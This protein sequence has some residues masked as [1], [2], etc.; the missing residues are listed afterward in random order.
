[1]YQ[2]EGQAGERLTSTG[3]N[4]EREDPGCPTHVLG[5]GEGLQHARDLQ[6]LAWPQQSALSCACQIY[7]KHFHG[8][9]CLTR[10]RFLAIHEFLGVE[11]VSIN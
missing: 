3:W 9:E 11:K 8:R 4:R 10:L 2:G 1:M 6:A 7:Q 5:T